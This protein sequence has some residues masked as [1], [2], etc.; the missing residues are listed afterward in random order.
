MCIEEP[1]RCPNLRAMGYVPVGNA[2]DWKAWEETKRKRR[3]VRDNDRVREK[4]NKSA[5]ESVTEDSTSDV[6]DE[7]IEGEVVDNSKTSAM[8]QDSHQVMP[9]IVK[10]YLPDSD[11]DSEEEEDLEKIGV[12]MGEAPAIDIEGDEFKILKDIEEV[13]KKI[14]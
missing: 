9:E 8:C 6:A 7:P 3:E 12:V 1:V 13:Q 4:Y 11:S 2:D 5:E 10:S 14:Q